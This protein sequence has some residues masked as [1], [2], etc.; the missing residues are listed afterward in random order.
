MLS[1]IFPNDASKIGN[2]CELTKIFGGKL[3]KKREKSSNASLHKNILVENKKYIA[4]IFNIP[5]ENKKYIVENNC[6]RRT[7]LKFLLLLYLL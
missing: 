4:V 7:L 6:S 2:Y 3:L 1:S 5:D